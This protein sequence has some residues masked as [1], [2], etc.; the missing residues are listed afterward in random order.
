M[1]RSALFVNCVRPRPDAVPVHQ[2]G[3]MTGNH[4]TA[5]QAE[6][7][8][9][10]DHPTAGSTQFKRHHAVAPTTSEVLAPGHHN[11]AEESR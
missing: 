9:P 8:V 11:F 2:S 7:F 10:R 5:L 1:L 6:G 3:E 4:L